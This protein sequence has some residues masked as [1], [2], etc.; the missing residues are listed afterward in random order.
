MSKL[1]FILFLFFCSLHSFSQES[2]S[3]AKKNN[4]DFSNKI[5]DLEKE[6]IETA[7]VQE[8][9][10]KEIVTI[11]KDDLC[12]VL[13]IKVSDLLNESMLKKLLANV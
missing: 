5:N 12:D 13:T 8:P 9:N 2:L 4:T 7:K 3:N 1:I 11:Y 6:K 10:K